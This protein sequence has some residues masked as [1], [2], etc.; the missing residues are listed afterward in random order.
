[1]KIFVWVVFSLK[2]HLNIVLQIKQKFLGPSDGDDLPVLLVYFMN[3]Y[4]SQNVWNN[5]LL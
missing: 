3:A 1:M 5:W 4:N 2:C